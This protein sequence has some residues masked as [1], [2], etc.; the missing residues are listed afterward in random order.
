MCNGWPGELPCG[1][2]EFWHFPSRAELR[3]ANTLLGRLDRGEITRLRMQ[4]KFALLTIDIDTGY[5]VDIG[6]EYRADFDYYESS[7]VYVVVDVKPSKEQ[8]DDPVFH[9]KRSIVEASYKIK[10]TIVRRP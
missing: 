1:N 7:G 9:L 10:I 5:P 2:R 3:H 8:A 4:P 6:R